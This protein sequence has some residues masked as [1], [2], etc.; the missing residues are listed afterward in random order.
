MM[1]TL[2]SEADMAAKAPSNK[3][4]TQCVLSVGWI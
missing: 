2:T 1:M 3:K 4:E